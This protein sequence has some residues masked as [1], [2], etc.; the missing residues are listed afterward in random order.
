MAIPSAVGDAIYF[1]SHSPFTQ[2][3]IDS[4]TTSLAD[5]GTG[6]GVW[7]Y[8]RGDNIGLGSYWAALDVN[9]LTGGFKG[10]SIDNDY[11]VS[12]FAPGFGLWKSCKAGVTD[13]STQESGGQ[14]HHLNKTF[15][16]QYYFVRYRFTT[17]AASA[18][19]LSRVWCGPNFWNSDLETNTISGTT[20]RRHATDLIS[21][22]INLDDREI[23]Q[24]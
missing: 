4:L 7:E 9:D 15:G 20:N 16:N 3:R 22:G 6:A 14:I 12:F 1:G 2:L 18:I 21:Y 23:T 10:Y 17:A 24:N 11:E 13:A 8:Y 5:G 19:S